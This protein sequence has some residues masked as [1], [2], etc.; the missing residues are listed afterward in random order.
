MALP[1]HNASAALADMAK[2]VDLDPHNLDLHKRYGELLASLGNRPAA[3]IQY[4]LA[5]QANEELDPHDA[6]RL[7]A[8]DVDALRRLANTK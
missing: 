2:A 4:Q 7:P 6:K 3:S 8:A 1:P 5:L